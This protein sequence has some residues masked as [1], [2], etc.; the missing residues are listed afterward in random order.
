MNITIPLAE[1]VIRASR[2]VVTENVIADVSE[3]VILFPSDGIKEV[4]NI[5]ILRITLNPKT[6]T[7]TKIKEKHHAETET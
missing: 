1:K 2:N 6:T 5:Q 3:L 4:H 7:N